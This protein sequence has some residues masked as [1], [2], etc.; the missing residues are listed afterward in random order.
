MDNEK[1]IKILRRLRKKLRR[2][3]SYSEILSAT[4]LKSKN[5][6]HRI[7]L[8]LIEQGLIR[9]DSTGR[10]LPGPRWFSLRLLGEVTAGWPSPAE[11]ELLDTMSL[12]EYLIDNKEA[13]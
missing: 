3:P 8:K 5:A 10:I 6:I 2:M 13:T 7:L 9:K 1:Y 12:E 11:E 4:G